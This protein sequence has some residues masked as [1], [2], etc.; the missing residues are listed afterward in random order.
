MRGLEIRSTHSQPRHMRCTCT[1]SDI[2]VDASASPALVYRCLPQRSVIGWH[3]LSGK[4]QCDGGDRK[5]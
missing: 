3:E 1:Q 4:N 5:G 2:T